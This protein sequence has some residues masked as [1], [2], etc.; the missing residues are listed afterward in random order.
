MGSKVGNSLREKQDSKWS[1]E[2]IPEMEAFNFVVVCSNVAM[3]ACSSEKNAAKKMKY[4]QSKDGI[5][6]LVKSK[7]VVCPD[8]DK[9]MK[10]RSGK[11]GPFYGCSQFPKCKRT[12]NIQL[13]GSGNDLL[14]YGA[15]ASENM[16]YGFTDD[17]ESMWGGK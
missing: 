10:F 14:A 2:H 8:C 11:F 3:I 4:L 6:D 1:I 5:A 17:D 7:T 16:G 9:P 15:T 13:A 12:R